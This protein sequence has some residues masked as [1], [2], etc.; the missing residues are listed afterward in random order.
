MSDVRKLLLALA[1]GSPAARETFVAWTRATATRDDVVRAE[2]EVVAPDVHAA[3]TEKPIRWFAFASL[4]VEPGSLATVRD[5]RPEGSDWL[6]VRERLAFDRSAR[7]DEARPW[8]GVKK[9]T[10]W[11]PAA[12]VDTA[13]WQ[14]RYSNHGIITAAHHATVVRYR[15]NVVVDASVTDV[16]AVSEL[17]WTNVEDLVER[18]YASDDARRLVGYDT[19][20]FV[21]A[22]RAHPVVTTHETLR[23]GSVTP[24]RAF[25]PEGPP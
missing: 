1:D 2:I 9:T 20:G 10:P 5:A 21:D 4:W 12:G 17:W 15:Q 7:A 23:A 8:A 14:A 3:H 22:R 11:A 16:G 25:L 24:T 6:L 18:F 13:L 19:L